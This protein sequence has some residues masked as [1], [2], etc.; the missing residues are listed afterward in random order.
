MTLMGVSCA[1]DGDGRYWMTVL[2]AGKPRDYL[3]YTG[4]LT[5]DG[6]QKIQAIFDLEA[7]MRT[8]AIP[9]TSG[10]PSGATR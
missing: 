3:Q 6:T 1:L 10:S 9:C 8:A 7:S 2:Y 4:P 5:L